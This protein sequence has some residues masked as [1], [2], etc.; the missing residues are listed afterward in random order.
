VE[1]ERQAKIRQDARAAFNRGLALQRTQDYQGAAREYQAAVDLDPMM[2]GAWTNLGL[3]QLN[4]GRTEQA[5]ESAR[6][7]LQSPSMSDPKRLAHAHAVVGHAAQ[8]AGLLDEARLAYAA[9]L[10]ANAAEESAAMALAALHFA[11]TNATDPQVDSPRLAAAA[12]TLA[13][14]HKAGA[15]SPAL[16]VNLA[17]LYLRMDQP[18]LAMEHAMVALRANPDM[19]EANLILGYAQAALGRWGDAAQNLSEA[20]HADPRNADLQVALGY[21]YESLGRR[22]DALAA[23][24]RAIALKSDHLEALTNRAV[25]LERMDQPQAALQAYHAAAAVRTAAGGTTPAGAGPTVSD[26]AATSRGVKLQLALIAAR[27]QKW[28]EARQLAEPIVAADPANAQARY[29]LGLSCYHLGDLKCASEQEYQLTLMDAAR[30]A[31]L[32]KLLGQH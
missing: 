19:P 2:A 23:F 21:A 1:A 24:D 3:C 10:S 31:S 26:T 11:P 30:A 27:V 25:T 15:Q 14:A 6:R 8:A 5:L 4:T 32:R 17:Q 16:Q 18:G 29:V 13:A 12:A 28:S 22:P 20:A 9:A 7:A